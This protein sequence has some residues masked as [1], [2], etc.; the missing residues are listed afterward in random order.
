MMFDQMPADAT[1]S[2]A[3]ADRAAFDA[4]QHFPEAQTQAFVED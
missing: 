1:A 4:S 3:L 2:R